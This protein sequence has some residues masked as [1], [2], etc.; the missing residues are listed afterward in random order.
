M[1]KQPKAKQEKKKMRSDVFDRFHT[2]F[3][4]FQCF[5]DFEPVNTK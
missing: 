2:L 5:L 3:C 4:C 1:R